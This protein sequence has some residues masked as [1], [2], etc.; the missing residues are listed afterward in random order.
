MQVLNSQTLL[1]QLLDQLQV[2]LSLFNSHILI[3]V[4]YINIYTKA[5]KNRRLY[6]I[7]NPRRW[8]RPSIPRIDLVYKY[9]I[10]LNFF[11]AKRIIWQFDN[12]IE[13][14]IKYFDAFVKLVNVSDL[15]TII[16]IDKIVVGK[17]WMGSTRSITFIVSFYVIEYRD[18]V[19]KYNE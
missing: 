12:K 16:R 13:C 10:W 7:E 19:S 2:L 3:I 18:H 4:R 1:Q 6:Y 11:K 9:W 14:Y 5:E 15:I 8:L 17:M